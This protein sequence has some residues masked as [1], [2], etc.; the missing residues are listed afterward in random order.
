MYCFLRWYL[1]LHHHIETGKTNIS[2]TYSAV[3]SGNFSACT[4]VWRCSGINSSRTL[5][6]TSCV[7]TQGWPSILP[8]EIPRW[9]AAAIRPPPSFPYL[10]LCAQE[11]VSQRPH[12]L[13]NAEIGVGVATVGP[14]YQTRRDHL[15]HN[16]SFLI[17]LLK[18]E[19]I[20]LSLH[21]FTHHHEGTTPSRNLYFTSRRGRWQT[22][23]L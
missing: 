12:L 10:I 2:S 6:L 13:H 18:N 22:L 23:K 20:L 17:I 15:A 11:R 16:L 9:T 1:G 19:Y 5:L 4:S 14:Q 21:S 3:R 7:D 8:D